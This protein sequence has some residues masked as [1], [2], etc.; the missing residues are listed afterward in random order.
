VQI[1]RGAA[2]GFAEIKG[3]GAESRLKLA[4]E[5]AFVKTGQADLLRNAHPFAP[6]M[7][8]GHQGEMVVE[9]Q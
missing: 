3:D 2:A 6:Q 8:R 7:G 4:R 9:G 5:G 1:L